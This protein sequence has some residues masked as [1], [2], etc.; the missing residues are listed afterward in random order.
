MRPIHP[1]GIEGL[2]ILRVAHPGT[3][4]AAGLP[5]GTPF[6]AAHTRS[7]TGPLRTPNRWPAT[8]NLIPAGAG[9]IPGVG[10]PPVL[11]SGRLAAKRVVGAVESGPG[12]RRIGR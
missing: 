7:Q 2:R 10:I 1:P 3:W 11:V 8:T 5:A 12:R 4:A 6:G 9:T